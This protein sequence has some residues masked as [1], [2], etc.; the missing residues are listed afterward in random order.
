MSGT[1]ATDAATRA[2]LHRRRA[3]VVLAL[4]SLVGTVV[5]GCLGGYTSDPSTLSPTAASSML[6]HLPASH[7]PDAGTDPDGTG[8]CTDV[9]P[10]VDAA[11]TVSALATM[12]LERTG[13]ETPRRR[14]AATAP[15]CAAPESA[16]HPSPSVLRI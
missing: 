16:S 3:S 5:L 13:V 12:P 7:A 11:V 15:S 8:G 4:L 6:T 14:A 2:R 9:L 1:G 10:H